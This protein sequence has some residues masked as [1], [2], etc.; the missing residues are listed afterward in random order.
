MAVFGA[1]LL[2]ARSLAARP[3]TRDAGVLSL[4]AAIMPPLALSLL[5]ELWAGLWAREGWLMPA[6]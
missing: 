1:V 4:A 2:V 5:G 6:H 3:F